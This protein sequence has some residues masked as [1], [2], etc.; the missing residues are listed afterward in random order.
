MV[1]LEHAAAAGMLRPFSGSKMGFL[2]G[3]CQAGKRGQNRVNPR[4]TCRAPYSG[5][6]VLRTISAHLEPWALGC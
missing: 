4:E 6:F 2:V 3:A 1:L 5:D